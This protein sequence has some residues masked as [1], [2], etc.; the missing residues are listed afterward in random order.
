MSDPRSAIA[1]VAAIQSRQKTPLWHLPISGP[2]PVGAWWGV[3]TGRIESAAAH[4]WVLDSDVKPTENVSGEASLARLPPL[5]ETF[6]V[7]T[8]GGGIHRYYRMP[9]DRDIPNRIDLLGNRSGIDVRGR[10]G[11]AVGPG[12]P[13][14]SVI[15]PREPV[16]AP[17]WLL[18]LVTAPV[19]VRGPRTSA[20]YPA[21]LVQGSEGY[22]EAYALA[23]EITGSE[24]LAPSG[25]R[26]HA[27]FVLACKL[28][29][30]CG[31]S[32]AETLGFLEWYHARILAAGLPEWRDFGIKAPGKVAS[33]RRVVPLPWGP[34]EPALPLLEWPPGEGPKPSP[35]PVSAPTVDAGGT[36][37]SPEFTK[38]GELRLRAALP[39]EIRNAIAFDPRWRAG[40][41]VLDCVHDAP[42]FR[43]EPPIP[44][45][46]RFGSEHAGKVWAPTSRDIFAIRSWLGESYGFRASPADV[47][48]AIYDLA[49]LRP[50]NPI[51][52][53]LERMAALPGPPLDLRQWAT[54]IFGLG[55][56]I[57]AEAFEKWVI[58]AVARGFVPGE[59][60]DNV[61]IL[62]GEQGFR[63]SSFFQAL[64]GA[65]WVKDSPI[66]DF[67]NRDAMMALSGFWC[68]EFPELQS[69]LRQDYD[70]AKQYLTQAH[71]D[72]RKMHTAELKRA[73]R[74]CVFAGTT[75]ETEIF[76]DPT[77]ARRFWP[78]L[79]THRVDIARVEREAAAVWKAAVALYRAGAPWFWDVEPDAYAAIKGEMEAVDPW[80]P[81]VAEWLLGCGLA[82]ASM[83]EI[84]EGA[85]YPLAIG[86]RERMDNRVAGRARRILQ[87]LGMREQRQSK[88]HRA[89]KWVI[90]AA[91][92]QA[93]A[94][95]IDRAPDAAP[96]ALVSPAAAGVV[97][98]VIQGGR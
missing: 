2:P 18:D 10:G 41:W 52:E 90:D 62:R 71:D 91:A 3:R 39:H 38:S 9:A 63:K 48:A 76:R 27:F 53:H 74:T 21:P 25:T 84:L 20:S 82:S 88:T 55:S 89:R 30:H 34:V 87:R 24:A 33:A 42:S 50:A 28:V 66:R 61:I 67:T 29:E 68:V 95:I 96:P 54:E 92:L 79:V 40:S 4:V 57:E 69:V 46:C 85:I 80:A 13:G 47:Q 64:F 58:A 93:A 31:L 51:A 81:Y 36:A 37:P 72:Y 5:P 12:A 16:D 14:Y 94:L 86:A 23:V 1:G 97:L 17:E 59:K 65:H 22:P 77:G 26:D 43:G 19:A 73:L 45:D 7:R 49:S 44:L 35:L 32:D 98:Q 75:N 83:G 56:A 70:V 15:D 60:V 78:L 6:A 8:G 11:F